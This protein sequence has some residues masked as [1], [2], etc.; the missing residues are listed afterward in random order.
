MKDTKALAILQGGPKVSSRLFFFSF[1]FNKTI[2]KYKEK[3]IQF[4]IKFKIEHDFFIMFQELFLSN[5][6]KNI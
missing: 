4:Q 3:L 6:K 5:V 1:S 2:P